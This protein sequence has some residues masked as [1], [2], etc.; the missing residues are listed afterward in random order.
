MKWLVLLCL[1]ISCGDDYGS[2]DAI[3]RQEEDFPQPLPFNTFSTR[4]TN[5]L[6]ISGK[7]CTGTE[8]ADFE[9][10]TFLC[11]SGLWLV[12]VDNINSCTPEGCTEVVVQPTIAGFR[13]FGGNATTRFLDFLLSIPASDATEDILADHLLRVDSLGTPTVVRK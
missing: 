8:V 9:G 13:E 3:D 10:R 5:N 2:Y 12:V 6:L 11:A 4:L 7:A 1:L